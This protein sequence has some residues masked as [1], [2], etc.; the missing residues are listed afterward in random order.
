VAELRNCRRCNK[1]FGYVT[2]P[3][4]CPACVR[5]DEEVFE[6]VS[7]YLRD[8]PGE[9]LAQVAHALDVGYERIMQYIREGRLQVR[10]KDGSLISFCEKCGREVNGGG[11]LCDSCAKGMNDDIA[12]SVKDLQRKI[13]AGASAGGGGFHFLKDGKKTR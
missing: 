4:L 9:P 8:T 2:G 3:V 5:E 7:M 11:R 6:R 10:A 13:P 12:S 1:V